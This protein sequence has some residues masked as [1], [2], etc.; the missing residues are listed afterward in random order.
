MKKYQIG[1]N[2]IDIF[3]RQ[4]RVGWDVWGNEVESDIDLEHLNK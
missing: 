1:E 4:K 3:A 2:R